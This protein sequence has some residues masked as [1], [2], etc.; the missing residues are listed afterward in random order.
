MAES[1]LRLLVAQLHQSQRNQQEL[2]SLTHAQRRKL[3]MAVAK[4][5]VLEKQLDY[6]R[7]KEAGTSAMHTTIDEGLTIVVDK[8]RN[9]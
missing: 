6:I 5:S 3:E 4:N 1:E 8:F 2:H 9:I 7:Y